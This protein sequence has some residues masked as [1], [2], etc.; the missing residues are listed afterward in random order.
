MVYLLSSA[1]EKQ[2]KLLLPPEGG[3]GFRGRDGRESMVSHS[4]PSRIFLSRRGGEG[5]KA[6]ST[7]HLFPI[8]RS[9]FPFPVRKGEFTPLA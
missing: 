5:E 9:R 8:D 6:I 2:K 3:K 1:R 7:S 4:C